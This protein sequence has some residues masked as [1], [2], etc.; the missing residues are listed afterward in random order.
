MSAYISNLRQRQSLVA[1]LV[2]SLALA[3]SA[4]L[5]QGLAA[6][7]PRGKLRAANDSGPG[8]QIGIK[9]GLVVKLG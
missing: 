4:G 6:E 9:T 3:P 5:A 2:A 8:R 7:D 1:I